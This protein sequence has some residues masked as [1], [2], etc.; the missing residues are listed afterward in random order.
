M[1]EDAGTVTL[2]V[3]VDNAVQGGFT[4]GYS[5][6]DGTAV[7]PADY[8]S[9]TGTVTFAGT[10][11][12]TE[13]FTVPIINDDVVESDETFDVALG[14]VTGTTPVSVATEI[15]A[16]D[17]ATVTIN[18]D[19]I[20]L[21]LSPITPATQV[22]GNPGDVTQYTFTVTRTGL[23]TGVTT[24]DYTVSGLAG[25]MLSATDG[26]D[27][28][29]VLTDTI[30]FA[31]TETVKTITIDVEEDLGVE[32]DEQFQVVLSNPNHL[33]DLGEVPV[34]ATFGVQ[35]VGNNQSAV[36]EN[37]DAATLTVS[38][39]SVYEDSTTHT[40]QVAV[41]LDVD[42]QGGF[43]VD[44]D[45]AD[46]TALLSNNDYVDS[47]GTLTFVGFAGEVQW[48]DIDI[49]GDDVVEPDE[50]LQVVLS[51]VVPTDPN[52]DPADILINGAGM[53][54]T[55]QLT[56][57][58]DGST[59]NETAPPAPTS[60][61][62]EL[63]STTNDADLLV[64]GLV[65]AG[66]NVV[67]GSANYLGGLNSSGFFTGGGSSIQLDSGI[68]LTTGGD[69]REAEPGFTLVSSVSSGSS[70]TDLEAE[71]GFAPGETADT[72]F[73]EFDF[74]STGGDLFF[75]FVF[76]SN[77][78]NGFVNDFNDAFAFFLDGTN[79]A[80]IPGT[81]TPVSINS[82][83]NG[84]A[85]DGVAAT[86]PQFYNN[87]EGVGAPF[88]TEFGFDGFTDVFQAAA[89]NLTPGVH[90]IK[91]AI[92]DFS[93]QVVNSA[94]FFGANS[95]S[96]TPADAFVATNTSSDASVTI[97]Q[98]QIDL[99][100]AGLVF[101]T[102]GASAGQPFT[103]S[104]GS[105]V[106][107]GLMPVIL[108]DGSSL[109]T[110]DFSDFS[111]T[112]S[113]TWQ[114]DVDSL[115]FDD[116]V[117]GDQLAGA[118]VSVN[119][120]NG[121]TA[122]GTLAAVG[123]NPDA[124]EV[125]LTTVPAVGP[126]GLITILNDDIDLDL[127]ASLETPQNEG[128]AGTTAYTF[129]V[130][131][132]GFITGSTED[133][134]VDW[135]VTGSGLNPASAD[136]F[137]GGVFPSGTVT[138]GPGEVSKTITVNVQGDDIAEMDEGFTVTLSNAANL[139][140]NL[141][142]LDVITVSQDAVIVNDDTSNVTID[143]VIVQEPDTGDPNV[144]ATFTIELDAPADR[145]I[146]IDVTTMD[147]TATLA[148][149]DYVS[150][151]QT[152]MIGPGDTSVSFSVPVVGDNQVELDENFFVVLSNPTYNGDPGD[153]DPLTGGPGGLAT[154]VR[155]VAIDDDTGEGI[156][157][158]ED[159]L[160]EFSLTSSLK[161]EDGATGVGPLIIVR[162]DLTGTSVADR[163]VSMEILAGTATRGID[164]FFGDDPAQLLPAEFVIPE[165]DYSG[166][167]LASLGKFDLTLFDADGNLASVSGNAPILDVV[168]DSLIEGNESLTVEIQG[169]GVALQKGN[170]DQGILSEPGRTAIL[171]DSTHI[172][173]DNDTATVTILPGQAVDEDGGTQSVT[174][175]LTTSGGGTATFAPGI[176][177]TLNAIDTLSGTATTPDDYG[178]SPQTLT[179]TS[180]DMHG[181]TR[182][183]D[184]TPA[185]DLL[186]EGPETVGLDLSLASASPFVAGGQFTLVG[187]DVEIT[188]N[189]NAVIGL[190]ASS[191]TVNEA[192]GTVTFDVTV[193]KA[194]AGGFVVD[195]SLTD[196][197]AT[198]GAADDYGTGATTGSIPFAGN[199]G[200]T[201]TI[202]VAIHDDL[203][204]ENTEDFTLM[205]T[206][207]TNNTAP[208]S[209]SSIDG[210]ADTSVASIIDNDGP[211]TI[212]LGDI[213]VNE[214]DGT[215]T[216]TATLD[217]AVQGGVTAD[218]VLTDGSADGSDYTANTAAV[219]FAGTAGETFS[220]EIDITDD[221][222][223]ENLEDLTVSLDNIASVGTVTSG[224]AT[225][226]IVDNDGPATITL[227]D[228]TVN[229]GD[230]TVT[231]TATLDTAVQGGVT[232]D[233]VLTDGS[234][235]GSDYT[236]NTA[237]VS[238][239][240]T[241]GETVSIEIDITDDTVIESLE[242]LTVSLGNIASV[243]TVTSDTATVSIVDNDSATVTLVANGPASIAE[244]AVA[245]YTL[246]LNG[247]TSSST[248]TT[249]EFSASGSARRVAGLAAHQVQDY[250]IWIADENGVF[251]EVTGNT[252]LIPA[253]ETSVTVELRAIDD[254]VVESTETA[255]LTLDGTAGD[256][257]F[258]G[259]PE[260]T[261]GAVLG[262][263]TDITDSDQAQLIIKATD[264]EARETL[265]GDPIDKATFT[266]ASVLPGSVS[267]TNPLGTPVP[268]AFNVSVIYFISTDSALNTIDY[269]SISGSV[270]LAP[271]VTSVPIDILP[272]DDGLSEGNETVTLTLDDTS[273]F[274]TVPS[275]PIGNVQ[276]VLG[277]CDA[278]TITIIENDNPPVVLDQ[279]FAIDENS[280]NATSVGTVLA[281]DP[282]L[283]AD[284]LSFDVTGGT[285]STAFAVDPTTGE[286][287][288]ADSAQLDFETTPTFTLDVEV[289]DVAGH[290]DTA[291]I[292]INLVD[293]VEGTVTIEDLIADSSQWEP[294]FRDFIDGGFNDGVAEGYRF[295][296]STDTSLP[297]VN[298]D[299][300]KIQFSE[301]VGASLDV[302]DFELVGQDG[303]EASYTPGATPNIT[304][305]TFDPSTFIATVQLDMP[306]SPNIYYFD[307]LAAGISSTTST[308]LAGGD[309]RLEFVALP[310]DS[311][312]LSSTTGGFYIVSGNDSQFVQTRQ[313]GFLF[314]DP[315]STAFD[316]PYFNYDIRADL[317]G[318]GAVDA[319]DAQ[320]AQM[321]QASFVLM[322]T[323]PPA[324]LTSQEDT[325][326]TG[327][328]P[329]ESLSG[330][331]KWVG[332]DDSTDDSDSAPELFAEGDELS[333][334][335]DAVDSVF[336]GLD[337]EFLN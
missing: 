70:D 121:T 61:P 236:A 172:I 41:T 6:S 334:Y 98:I 128:D 218:V 317:D 42:V 72:T 250:S 225:V 93:D 296:A 214:G 15:D 10:A 200:E 129:E 290:T 142:T 221:L 194:V 246:G 110:L 131:R 137:V 161:S 295:L 299:R 313:A 13:T 55:S 74:I 30:T 204:V 272:F 101:D 227:G 268:I 171:D 152:V 92:S 210:S 284:A 87:N 144:M 178:F 190:T 82:V 64:A 24:V 274:S 308:T 126:T 148:D 43:T 165:G 271:G 81:M 18:N 133:T 166:T 88:A 106:D 138:F 38:D 29:S 336:G 330:E 163:T 37:D 182:T 113:L 1:D 76:A 71:F 66:I 149:N 251:S 213:T 215:V 59:F 327:A 262:G 185:S 322:L 209:Q 34:D 90:T 14:P 123:G 3:A 97:D 326:L 234:A 316:G 254:I 328:D 232:A 120:S 85:N 52:V 130:T 107:T 8:T 28:A 238:F 226:S 287:T 31:A 147:G 276:V 26:A 102:G 58:I 206:G 50:Q 283:P 20:D 140:P 252:L 229:E 187:N 33:E 103:P 111:Q 60:G 288:V 337:D 19:D 324:A 269:T 220:I 170:A 292:T 169:L 189:D 302:S 184:L 105:D 73:L 155:Q 49:V 301:D 228:I 117:T 282:D 243:G 217:T 22:E 174:V 331:S 91:L 289:T 51:N 9:T 65:G 53:S 261:L 80:L 264:D 241:A 167:D 304:G 175:E 291:T 196:G 145:L 154:G 168:D 198:N 314:D 146:T 205:L 139:D 62:L 156:I 277:D 135:A 95:F 309:Q 158:N 258:S 242:D 173:G 17:G 237:A 247:A 231:V 11:G 335:E 249:V 119:F 286:I 114:V 69:A 257:V 122:T 188:D 136:D 256:A 307:I 293:L 280:P 329:A 157:N 143:D 36:I 219:S 5:T 180:A 96:G 32:A 75:D 177:V 25:V 54:P 222:V 281:T 181:A 151:S 104:F 12:E 40:I 212:T 270:S 141:D 263:S 48:I 253:G 233:V 259:D 68:V 255:T 56:L 108:A 160:I 323:P 315:A 297:W 127:M 312:D 325:S 333:D 109:L 4:V 112:E 320:A 27:F 118:T 164:Y 298:V 321:R 311:V 223:I 78:Y 278:D 2:T 230:G 239:A 179:F 124:V 44:Y 125:V 186:V 211:A 162:G 248:D 84:P 115:G 134:T 207:V 208:V 116:V 300:L 83:N 21:T 16:T 285:G 224:T 235:D 100:T 67:P 294:V 267:P 193:D 216:V 176:T 99:S 266:V 273:E 332:S 183:I 132:A 306:L 305:V 275:A 201:Q 7:D 150:T 153:A 86:N 199:A 244:G 265:A 79:I 260:I 192:D 94:V 45:T 89:I 310:G 240:G 23:T 245:T 197:T 47:V 319:D 303:F 63:T 203:V 195:Y 191:V 35:L 202:T 39:V 77:E 57:S 279:T 159:A 318:D 46:I